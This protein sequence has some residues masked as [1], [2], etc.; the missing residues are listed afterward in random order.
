M[1]GPGSGGARPGSG[2]KKGTKFKATIS[3]M[4]AREIARQLIM[5][6]ADEMFRAQMQHSIGIQHMMLRGPDGKFERA[7]D[8]D[9]I[10]KAL[11]SGD[12]N[13][14]YIFTKDPSV[15]AF[16]DL[17]N[18]ALDK[19]KEQPQDVNLNVRNDVVERLA[20]A[21]ERSKR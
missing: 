18:R 21:R 11:N 9:Q 19:P 8:P 20:K 17:M 1:G 6:R 13:S 14:Y 2:N 12:E 7:T 5:T 4:E 3:K 10:L 16:T 15:Q